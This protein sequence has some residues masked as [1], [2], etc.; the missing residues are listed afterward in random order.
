MARKSVE[1]RQKAEAKAKAEDKGPI[2]ARNCP[3]KAYFF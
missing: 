2:K 3:R 1:T